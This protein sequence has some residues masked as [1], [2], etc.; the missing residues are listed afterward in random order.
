MRRPIA[1]A[2]AVMMLMS[3]LALMFSEM[4]GEARAKTAAPVP[5]YVLSDHSYL[6]IQDI[7][8]VW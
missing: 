5:E 4:R 8:P 7:E 1:I 6:P 2:S 3:L